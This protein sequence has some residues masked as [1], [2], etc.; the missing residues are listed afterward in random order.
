MNPSFNTFSV[1]TSATCGL[2]PP[3][4]GLVGA[5]EQPLHCCLCHR[6]AAGLHRP[7]R[8]TEESASCM[9]HSLRPRGGVVVEKVSLHCWSLISSSM[10]SS[11]YCIFM[12][13]R[14]S[15]ICAHLHQLVCWVFFL[16]L[17]F[18]FFCICSNVLTVNWMDGA[19][20]SLF[21]SPHCSS[22]LSV[23]LSLRLLVPQLSSE[24]L[25]ITLYILP[26]YYDS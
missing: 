2:C 24:W 25:D 3:T 14:L 12:S 21:L 10:K 1:S 17:F 4:S 20:S 23:P 8:V 5:L 11:S 26:F 18:F 6:S 16:T 15:S 19:H 9:W 7:C 13:W 22:S